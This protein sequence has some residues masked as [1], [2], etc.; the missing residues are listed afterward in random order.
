MRKVILGIA[1]IICIDVVFAAYMSID[2]RDDL[3]VLSPL[4]QKDASNEDLPDTPSAEE[5]PD[6]AL[7]QIAPETTALPGSDPI[8]VVRASVK[9][10]HFTGKARVRAVRPEKEV[11]ASAEFSDVTIV[12]A[13][14]KPVEFKASNEFEAQSTSRV[15]TQNEVSGQRDQEPPKTKNRSFGSRA[16]PILK[17]PYEV[18]KAIGSKFY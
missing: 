15:D 16:M 18:I 13:A 11:P 8:K 5:N 9:Q 12:Y 6:S 17:K 1:A 14:Y 3:A 2:Q 10:N 4:A 7:I